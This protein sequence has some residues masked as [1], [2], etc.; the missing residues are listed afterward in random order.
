MF[1]QC[2]KCHK[3]WQYNIAECPYCFKLLERMKSQKAEVIGCSY[4][5][6]PTILHPDVPYYVLALRDEYGN[7]WSQKSQKE[8]RVGEEFILESSR[9]SAAVA[10]WKNK[11]DYLEQI[12]KLAGMLGDLQ[13]TSEAKI[14]IIPTLSQPSHAYYRDNTS[15]EFLDAFLEFLL[16]KGVKAENI[17]VLG[18]SFDSI[19]VEGKAQKSGLVAVCMKYK[20]APMDIAKGQFAQVRGYSLSKEALDANLVIAVPIAKAGRISACESLLQVLEKDEAL[21]FKMERDAIADLA[22]AFPNLI[23]FMDG[24][25]IQNRQEVVEF[26]GVGLAG[27]NPLFVDKV[28]AEIIKDENQHPAIKNISPEMIRILGNQIK[29]ASFKI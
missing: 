20:V 5:T 14:A 4:G 27:R 12:E 23:I 18:Q 8:Y 26:L 1:Y 3:R 22:S 21:H 11:Y 16:I 15:P 10:V 6:I 24:V 25:H 2:P 7:I 17:K 9:E 28:F 19:P 13:L 29:D